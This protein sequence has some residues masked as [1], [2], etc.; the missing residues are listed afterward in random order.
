MAR[1]QR[2]KKKYRAGG[3]VLVAARSAEAGQEK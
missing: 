1:A 2:E 3:W